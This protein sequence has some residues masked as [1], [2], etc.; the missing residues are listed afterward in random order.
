MRNHPILVVICCF[1]FMSLFGGLTYAQEQEQ[2]QISETESKMNLGIGVAYRNNIY[3]GADDTAIPIPLIFFER[4]DFYIKGVVAGYRIFKQDRLSL[5][6][7]AQWRFDGYEEDDS[8]YLDGMGDHYMNFEGG[9]ALTYSDGWGLMRL[10][11][12]NDLCDKHNGQEFAFS[13]SKEFTKDRWSFL[14][15]AGILWDSSDMTDYFYGVESKYARPGRP[16]YSVGEAWN[17]F[18]GLLTNYQ[19]NEKWSAMASLRYEFLDNEIAD[20]PIVSDDYKLSIIA[21][22][23]YNF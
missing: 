15:T 17:P 2:E 9:L 16:A 13:Y 21:G 10:S 7:I 8:D 23:M 12:V 4:G 3:K 20:S 19:F 11:F 1:V 5:H 22:L 18:L 14:P 6:L